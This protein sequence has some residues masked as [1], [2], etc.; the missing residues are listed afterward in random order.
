M[1]TTNKGREEDG[2]SLIDLVRM[3]SLAPIYGWLFFLFG[4]PYLTNGSWK[5][6]FLLKKSWGLTN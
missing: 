6:V 2:G 4:I 1:G 5:M 3:V